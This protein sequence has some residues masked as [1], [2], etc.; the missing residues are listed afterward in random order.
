MDLSNTKTL[1]ASR[2][3]ILQK[4]EAG[5]L[6]GKPEIQSM[7]EYLFAVTATIPELVKAAKD[8]ESWQIA[9]LTFGDTVDAANMGQIEEFITQDF[10]RIEAASVQP[11][12]DTETKKG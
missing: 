7:L 8:K 11:V 10:E 12:D 3:Q 9:V 5:V 1:T 4:V 2:L 6:D